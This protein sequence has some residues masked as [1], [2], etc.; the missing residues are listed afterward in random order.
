M[1]DGVAGAV[2]AIEAEAARILEEARDTAAGILRDARQEAEAI[3][4][5]VLPLD[6]VEAKCNSLLKEARQEAESAVRQA[7]EEVEALRDGT[8]ARSGDYVRQLVSIVTGA[9]P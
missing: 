5:E 8:A 1:T 3:S 6:D 9:E 4:T 2:R 7:A